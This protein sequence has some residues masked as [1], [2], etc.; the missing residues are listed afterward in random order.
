MVK[1]TILSFSLLLSGLLSGASAFA[2]STQ[3][4]F[5]RTVRYMSESEGG[6]MVPIK[7]ETV[8]FTAGIIG[9][10]VGLVIG[11]PV[12]AAVGAAAV[13]YA[14]K[15]EG[16]AGVVVSAVSKTAIEVY[17]YLTKLDAKYEVLKTAQSKLEESLEKVKAQNADTD[18]IQQIED[19]LTK[20]TSSIS[21]VNDEYDLVGAGV[22]ALGVVG[23][24]VE[25]AVKK[26]SELNEE[27][28]L[29]D[30][31]TAALADATS[32]AKS[33]VSEAL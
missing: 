19:A 12:V 15:A 24:L 26:A 16:E 4:S 21:E 31:A 5:T 20:V 1:A 6:A 9:G 28:Q 17:N 8:E 18:T 11:G 30:K 14:S 13:N 10:A 23:D 7:E 33:K 25:K 22:T 32:K 29:T 3:P 2:P 27:Y